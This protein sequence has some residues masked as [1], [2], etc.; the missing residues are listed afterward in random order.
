MTAL[1]EPYSWKTFTVAIVGVVLITGLVAGI[2][3]LVWRLRVEKRAVQNLA[4][5]SYQDALARR[6]SEANPNYEDVD[7]GGS[8]SIQDAIVA[9]A[10]EAKRH[11][12]AR[13][14][15]G[16]RVDNPGLGSVNPAVL[17]FDDS[18]DF[19]ELN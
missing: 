18:L 17:I 10:M 4:A 11:V 14:E 16:P 3:L 12:P 1:L 5:I 8:V 9:R 2:G 15:H 19:N 13:A 6:V 7:N